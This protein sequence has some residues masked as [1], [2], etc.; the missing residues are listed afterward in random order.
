MGK[1]GMSRRPRIWVWALA[2][3]LVLFIVA[4]YVIPVSVSGALDERLPFENSMFEEIDGVAFHYRT[5]LPKDTAARGK[6]LLVHGLAGSTFSFEVPALRLSEQGYY[7]VSVDLPGFGY[8]DRDPAYDH[9]QA[10]RAGDLWQLLSVVEESLPNGMKARP[11]HL[12]GHSMGGGTV[13]AMAIQEPSR[14]QSIVF[15]DAAL[16][17][18]P[19]GSGFFA[20]PPLG[21]WMM[22]ALEY[23]LI[24]EDRIKSLLTS[25]YGQEPS[26]AQIDA[27]LTP[28]RLPGTARSLLNVVQTA[29]NEDPEKL[30][31]ISVP[32][33]AVW[34]DKDTWVPLQELDKLT[35][36]RPNVTVRLISGA[37]HCPMET[38]PEAFSAIVLQW[39]SSHPGTE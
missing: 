33:L 22:T 12:G 24:T 36:I 4:P 19:R 16:S 23:F 30:K 8:S 11:W 20:F 9:S 25:A 39:L 29:K 5:Y 3:F 1:R 18:T 17:E 38:H 6:L 26:A 27:Y 7:V 32:I 13:A 34:G 2:A 10:N 14:V 28:L 35:A 31:D 15:V 37:A 21:R